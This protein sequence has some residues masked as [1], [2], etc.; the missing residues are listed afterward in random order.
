MGETTQAGA[1]TAGVHEMSQGG[2]YLATLLPLGEGTKVPIELR[3]PDRTVQVEVTVVWSNLIGW[4]R[5][6]GHPTGMAVKFESLSDDDMEAIADYL[7]AQL[8]R[9]RV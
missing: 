8:E 7:G 3:L 9:F 6:D 5:R 4:T 1:R 2:A